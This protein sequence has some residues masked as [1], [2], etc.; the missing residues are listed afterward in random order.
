ME[1]QYHTQYIVKPSVKETNYSI[2]DI[3]YTPTQENVYLINNI[4]LGFYDKKYHRLGDD[5][6]TS[7]Y[8]NTYKYEKRKVKVATSGKED[9]QKKTEDN[10]NVLQGEDD[11]K[12]GDMMALKK[13]NQTNTK[14]S[15]IIRN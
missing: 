13:R 4:L 11:K 1:A 5:N 10:K 15:V 3:N 9:P 2:V 12:E 14:Q 6:S 8:I 7:P